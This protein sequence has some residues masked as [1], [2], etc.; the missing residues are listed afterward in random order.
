MKRQAKV[1]SIFDS[2]INYLAI[3]AGII[4]VL[5][6]FLVSADVIS[7]KLLNRPITG[8]V[9][10]SEIGL[11]AITFLAAA[12][13]LR[14]EGHVNIDLVLN[15][16]SPRNQALINA[17][18]S[19]VGI[20]ICLALTWYS[21]MVAVEHFQ[22]GIFSVYSMLELPTY[23]RFVIMAA[24]SLLLIVQFTRRSQKFLHKWRSLSQAKTG[25]A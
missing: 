15:M 23:P 20:I 14:E 24:G 16:L 22:E 25:G 8:S 1:G 9:E 10:V 2:I 4:T 6:M 3:L 5:M 18:T 21:V 7:R 19:F 11:L 13:L 12:W 17:I